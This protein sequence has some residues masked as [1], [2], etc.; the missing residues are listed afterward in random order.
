[1]APKPL[2]SDLLHERAYIALRNALRRGSFPLDRSVPLRMLSVELG[3]SVTPVR[4]A[5]QRLIAEGALELTATRRI[6]VP[7][8]T[9]AFYEEIVAIRL[10]LEPM[11]LAA[12]LPQ[13]DQTIIAT[14]RGLSSQMKHAIADG[15][16]PD[17]LE[18]NESFHFLLYGA[19]GLDYLLHLIGNCWL[20]CGPWLARL[21]AEGRFYEIA[22][23]EH[24][25]M[26]DALERMDETALLVALGR[27]ISD[28]AHA[29][30]PHLA[31]RTGP[32]LAALSD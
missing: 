12:A 19:S 32:A 16:F 28:A 13:C 9:A 1:M 27:D 11:A 22:N 7:L 26:I 29:L 23:T 15:R 2:G 4:E 3:I 24:D 17:Y 6:R 20:R 10:Q 31:Q 18:A 30:A 25:N 21:A 14:A 5:V 8:M